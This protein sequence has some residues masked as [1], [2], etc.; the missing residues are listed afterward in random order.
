MGHDEASKCLNCENLAN[1]LRLL[2][3][4]AFIPTFKVDQFILKYLGTVIFIGNVVVWKLVKKTKMHRPED[5]DLVTGRREFEEVE[6][7]DDHRWNESWWKN[8]GAKLRLRK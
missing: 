4:D 7:T 1:Y 2:G 5:V 6:T 8:V 3:Y